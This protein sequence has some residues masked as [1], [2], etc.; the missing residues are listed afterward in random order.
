MV[1]FNQLRDHLSSFDLVLERSVILLSIRKGLM[2]VV[3]FL[4]IGSF[5]LVVT[6]LP[7]P[8]YQHLMTALWGSHWK[9]IWDSIISGSFGILSI[10]MTLAVSYSYATESNERGKPFVNPMIAALV[11]LCSLI[12][13][14]GFVNKGVSVAAFG[15]SGLFSAILVASLSAKLFMALSRLE[16]LRVRSFTDGASAAFNDAIDGII[17]S[18]ITVFLFAAAGFILFGLFG[19]Q[20]LQQLTAGIF[21]SLFRHLGDSVWSALLFILL[22]HLFWIF[23]IHGNN[24]LDSVARGI[25][26]PALT[27]NQQLVANHLAPVHVF[28]KTFF[29]VFVFMGGCGGTL[30]L[31]LAI[32]LNGRHKNLRRHAAF[33]LVPVLFN[34]NELIVFGIPI[35]LNPVYIIPFVVTP[36]LLTLV[37]FTATAAGMVPYTTHGVEWTTPVLLGGYSATGSMA[38]SL[39][40]VLNLV[41]GTACYLPFVHIAEHQ[42]R[43]RM[44]R[45]LA[46]IGHAI[47]DSPKARNRSDLIARHDNVGMAARALAADLKH[48]LDRDRLM[49]FYQPQVDDRGEIIGVEALLRWKHEIYGSIPPQVAIA[50]AEES[51]VFDQLDSWILDTACRKLRA[52]QDL[53][54]G[55]ITMSINTTAPRL[56]GNAVCENLKAAIA[57]YGIPPEALK[58]EITEKDALSLSHG[59]IQRMNEIRALGVKLAMDDFGMGHTSLL[60]LRECIFDTVKIDGSLVTGMMTNPVCREIISTIVALGRTLSFSVIAEFVETEAERDQLQSLGCCQ[61]QGYLYS[62]G[63]SGEELVGFIESWRSRLA[64]VADPS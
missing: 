28:T 40:Q 34:V 36:L 25:Y 56:E 8:A 14:S 59:T 19:T 2:L 49:L 22:I 30:C 33:S 57:T 24:V 62:K 38:G 39:L 29:D 51:R 41:L 46:R 26:A 31:V 27:A 12:T 21:V 9:F 1:L 64:L 20:D 11:S 18:L 10:I 15:A 47:E 60:Y 16:R 13:L 63:L 4:L 61:Y 23:G 50:L 35:V 45:T 3:P 53:G 7:V 52:L 32:F 17:P 44:K 43:E 37:A 6:S 48:D 55:G 42:T 58:I 5:A 54:I